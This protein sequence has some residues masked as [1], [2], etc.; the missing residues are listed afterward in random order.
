MA[1]EREKVHSNIAYGSEHQQHKKS[2]SWGIVLYTTAY[3]ELGLNDTVFVN[4][5]RIKN[6]SRETD[7]P[8]VGFSTVQNQAAAVRQ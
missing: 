5:N 2:R 3:T 7:V 4:V 8:L 6:D 1:I